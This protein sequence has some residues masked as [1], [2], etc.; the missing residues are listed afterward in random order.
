MK[1]NLLFGCLLM[2]LVGFS[3]DPAPRLGQAS[4]ADNLRNYTEYIQSKSTANF[5]PGFMETYYYDMGSYQMN[6]KNEYTYVMSN[7]VATDTYSY[8]DGSSLVLSSRSVYSYDPSLLVVKYEWWDDMASTWNNSWVDS[9]YYDANGKIIRQAGYAYD[10]ILEVWD[11][12]WGQVVTNTYSA[13]NELLTSTYYTLSAAGVGAPDYRETWTWTGG[14]GP[15]A[16]LFQEWDIIS[17]TWQDEMRA[18]GVTWFDFDQFM[19][20]AATL[21]FWTGTAWENGA[22]LEAAYYSNG[23]N[24][25][26]IE[27]EWDGTAFVNV[28]KSE[29]TIDVN[30]QL[31]TYFAYNWND[32]SNEWQISYGV[33]NTNT[34]A[35]NDALTQV[36]VADYDVATSTYN[37][38]YRYVY[39]DHINVASLNEYEQLNAV[40]Y[41]NPA[42]DRLNVKLEGKATSFEVLNLAGQTLISGLAS[43]MMTIDVAHLSVGLYILK[44]SNADQMNTVKFMKK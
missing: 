31:T 17:S 43:E 21:E 42:S 33:Q 7:R 27:K 16:G 44:I 9:T 40:L 10:D 18:T 25:Y 8:F 1:K 34:Y 19:V 5:I 30:G 38:Y 2:S 39:G 20:T 37:P 6:G 12:Q 24:E 35:A 41:P 29:Q 3:Q 4:N 22:Q 26:T 28:Y 23:V 11:F 15:S 36:D 14:N 13:A 32:S